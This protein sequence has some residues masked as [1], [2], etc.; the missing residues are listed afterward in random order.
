MGNLLIESRK[1]KLVLNV[2]LV[3]LYGVKRDVPCININIDNGK[4]IYCFYNDYNTK[5]IVTAALILVIQK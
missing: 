3:Y 2:V 1:I 4:C 5:W